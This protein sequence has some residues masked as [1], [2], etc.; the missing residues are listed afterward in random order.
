MCLA[1]YNGHSGSSTFSC[2]N[3]LMGCIPHNDARRVHAENDQRKALIP[4]L[5]VIRWEVRPFT[6]KTHMDMLN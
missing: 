1:S 3:C 2:S 6:Y 4:N 5:V